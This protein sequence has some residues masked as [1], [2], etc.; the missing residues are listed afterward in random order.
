MITRRKFLTGV[1]AGAVAA[2]A[3]SLGLRHFWKL[4]PRSYLATFH[5]L[6]ALGYD[7]RNK[8]AESGPAELR[9]WDPENPS[10][11]P[12]SIPLKISPHHIVQ[13]PVHPTIVAANEKWARG[14]VLLDFLSGEILSYIEAPN[15]TRFFGH[16]AFLPDGKH[17][18]FSASRDTQEGVLLLYD[19]TTARLL[20]QIPA[21]GYYTHDL[22]VDR[23]GKWVTVANSGSR[24]DESGT[25]TFLDLSSGKETASFDTGHIAHICRMD[26]NLWVVCGGG[27]P[28]MANLRWIDSNSGRSGN[29]LDAEGSLGPQ[30]AQVLSLARLDNGICAATFHESNAVT[31]W[32]LKENRCVNFGFNEKTSGIAVYKN[33]LYLNLHTSGNLHAFEVPK[34]ALREGHSILGVGRHLSVLTV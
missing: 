17:V 10:T 7:H 26:E 6:Q 27:G 33:N 23:T 1:G 32:N 28:R 12:R 3:F 25:L 2:A 11:A 34:L 29:Y 9:I 13:N 18:L 4:A 16:S 24:A 31:F 5:P 15:G 22:H 21:G 30:R 19:S 14:A 8:T 20:E